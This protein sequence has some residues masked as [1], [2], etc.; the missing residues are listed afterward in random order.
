MDLSLKKP[1]QDIQTVPL[2]IPQDL[3]MKTRRTDNEQHRDKSRL[4]QH[5]DVKGIQ[6]FDFYA[7]LEATSGKGTSATKLQTEKFWRASDVFDKLADATKSREKVQPSCPVDGAVKRRRRKQANPRKILK[8]EMECFDVDSDSETSISEKD[9]TLGVGYDHQEDA[10]YNVPETYCTAQVFSS[11]TGLENWSETEDSSAHNSQG[12]ATLPTVLADYDDDTNDEDVSGLPQ[13]GRHGYKK[14]A[15]SLKLTKSPKKGSGVTSVMLLNREHRR[16]LRLFGKEYTTPSGKTYPERKVREKDCSKC[17][18]NCSQN[19][20][21]DQQQAIF[22]HFW[23]LNSYV[24]RLYYYCQSIKE[25]PAK[26]MTH[27]RECSREYTFL[28]GSERIRVCKG[29]YL[30]TLDVSDKAVRIAMEKRKKGMSLSDK[31]GNHP[32]HNKTKPADKDRVR[33]HIEDFLLGHICVK[34]S[35]EDTQMNAAGQE[36]NITRMHQ[37]YVQECKADGKEAVSEDVYRKTFN[38]EYNLSCTKVL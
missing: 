7:Y 31:R 29:F 4:F 34:G 17:R 38:A 9:Y 23:G 20:S 35:T 32:P 26:T 8:E 25:K 3:S 30:A 19:I 1:R 24:K 2:D 22:D 11:D 36:V 28:V 16:R 10:S 6:Q 5:S 27:T 37:L 12:L 33:R 18:Y 13:S 15:Q 21:R 14:L